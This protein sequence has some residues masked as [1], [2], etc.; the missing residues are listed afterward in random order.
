M[1]Y[2]NVNFVKRIN[3]GRRVQSAVREIKID[4][5]FWF[6]NWEGYKFSIKP[7]L[8]TGLSFITI[9]DNL[10][11]F[12]CT[13]V[14]MSEEDFFSKLS[15][16]NYKSYA[17]LFS[18]DDNKVLE[19]LMHQIN[20]PVSAIAKYIIGVEHTK[21]LRQLLSLFI[22]EFVVVAYDKSA[23]T[24][25]KD[26]NIC[27]TQA[28]SYYLC[29][30]WILQKSKKLQVY[31][32]K[33]IKLVNFSVLLLELCPKTSIHYKWISGEI[34]AESLL[35]SYTKKGIDNDNIPVLYREIY[36][37]V[38]NDNDFDSKYS[39]INSIVKLFLETTQVYSK[40]VIF[41]NTICV[42]YFTNG[43]YAYD[44][45]ITQNKDILLKESSTNK[46]RI[47][48]E[49]TTLRSQL[50]DLRKDNKD[51][52]SQVKSLSNKVVDKP[53][54]TSSLEH[55][56]QELKSTISDLEYSI[57][58]KD[59]VLAENKKKIRAQIK[60]I[61]SLNARLKN[62]KVDV[63]PSIQEEVSTVN[64]NE[65]AQ[66]LVGYH[67][68]VFGGFDIHNLVEKFENYG[69]SIRHIVD[70]KRFNVGN[71][72]CAVI[73]TTN[74]QHKIVARLKSQY[75]GKIIY[76]N[77]MNIENMIVELYNVLV[78]EDKK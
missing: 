10:L 72:D 15:K 76:F 20:S 14:V 24:I 47:V 42:G 78:S 5:D 44:R 9:A 39:S 36:D 77:G 13:S 18:S 54:D 2:E 71:L 66:Q 43:V 22:Q 26:K 50:K 31:L 52:K 75:N 55:N 45:E 37:L 65:L 30:Y 48:Q 25:F 7:F 60:E 67:I 27:N 16:F 3:L 21:T 58:Q 73:L 68:G 63:Q 64:I 19:T 70:E 46:D 56:I 49:I 41:M 57:S 28:F 1:Y 17:D 38:Q 40:Y 12:L 23:Y 51:L 4:S 33:E 32:S 69:L 11:E 62:V 34:S 8:C 61:K 29:M 59:K 53:L 6:V 35:L 74:I